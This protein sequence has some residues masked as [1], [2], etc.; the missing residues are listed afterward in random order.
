MDYQVDDAVSMLVIRYKLRKDAEI[1]LLQGRNFTGT[2]LNVD[3]HSLPNTSRNS[4][5]APASDDDE[6][7]TTQNE[8]GSAEEGEEENEVS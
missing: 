1:A 3:W 4:K 8:G 5:D 2:N 6:V 7:T